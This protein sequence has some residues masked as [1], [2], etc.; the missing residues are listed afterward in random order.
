M[1]ELVYICYCDI[2]VKD[3][4]KKDKI[5]TN[6]IDIENKFNDFLKKIGE[7]YASN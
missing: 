6:E 5:I 1:A 4:L 2:Y 7:E 3:Q